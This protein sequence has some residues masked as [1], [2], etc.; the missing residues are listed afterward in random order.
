MGILRQKSK[1]PPSEVS[2]SSFVRLEGFSRRPNRQESRINTQQVFIMQLCKFFSSA[3]TTYVAQN[4]ALVPYVRSGLHRDFPA[5]F[6]LW[7][8]V[9]PGK[10]NSVVQSD[11]ARTITPTMSF[12][13]FISNFRGRD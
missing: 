1:K 9:W 8:D 13:L 2:P 10:S 6:L 7:F 4:S 12:V 3:H 11:V 5:R